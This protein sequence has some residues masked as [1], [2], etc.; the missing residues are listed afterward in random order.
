MDRVYTAAGDNVV[1]IAG[2]IKSNAQMFWLY[3]Y[4]YEIHLFHFCRHF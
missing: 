3:N 2:D 1:I 4:L